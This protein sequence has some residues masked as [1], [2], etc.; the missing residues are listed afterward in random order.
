MSDIR[1]VV[2]DKDGTL[3]DFA[4]TWESWARSFLLRLAQGDRDHAQRLGAAV[5]FD[6]LSSQFRSDSLVIAGTPLEIAEVLAA[7]MPEMSRDQLVEVL[8]VEAMQ[9]PQSEAVPLT[10]LLS[11][12]RGR[13]LRLGVVT[14]DA[15]AP[16]LAHLEASGVRSLFDFIAGSDSGFGAKPA[17]GQLLAFMKAVALPAEAS[18]MV[19]DSL[20][21]LLAGR[22][23]GMHTVG[24]LTGYADHAT[25]APHADVVLPDI[26]ALPHWL[27]GRALQD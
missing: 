9:A 18:V 26:G 7:Q 22:A 11:E 4:T 21:D 17:P 3:F 13:G 8:N 12:L 20:H 1:A 14:N 2:F 23:A 25:L 24:V 15:E 19:G 27:S 10:P 5:G 6:L 16:A